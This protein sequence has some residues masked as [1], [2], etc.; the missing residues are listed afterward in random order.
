[1]GVGYG[2]KEH[3]PQI[4]IK[5]Q[6]AFCSWLVL[7]CHVFGGCQDQL[8]WWKVQKT[9]CCCFLSSQSQRNRWLGDFWK[10][11]VAIFLYIRLFD[12]LFMLMAVTIGSFL[13]PTFRNQ[14][15]A[16]H[17]NVLIHQLYN[18]F[19][20]RRILQDF[21]YTI[22]TWGDLPRSELMRIKTWMVVV[23]SR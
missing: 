8:K 23:K 19:K 2:T 1:M 6:T 16:A 17:G 13:W 11:I 12:L 7:L 4:S 22:F 14:T 10:F 20:F 9:T 21:L 15:V 18:V 3:W 5:I